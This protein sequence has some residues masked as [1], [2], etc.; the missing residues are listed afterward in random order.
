MAFTFPDHESWSASS[1]AAAASITAAS[2]TL[3]ILSIAGLSRTKISVRTSLVPVQV[4]ERV[5]LI[6]VQLQQGMAA[7][8]NFPT[9]VSLSLNSIVQWILLAFC[10]LLSLN[11]TGVDVPPESA[12]IVLAVVVLGMS[13]PAVPGYVGTIE[14][15][16]VVALGFFGVEPTTAFSAALYYHAIT[17]VSVTISGAWFFVMQNLRKQ[18]HH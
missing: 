3:I 15:G 12:V 6:I 2:A 1:L 17:F 10:I 7:A 5:N 4:R 9:I 13:L 11:A 16:F 18:H 14:Y 8:N